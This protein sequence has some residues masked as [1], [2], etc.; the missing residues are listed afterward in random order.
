MSKQSPQFTDEMISAYLDGELSA[1]ERQCVEEVMARDPQY[2]QMLEELTMLRDK[3]KTL[4]KS[5]LDDQ[6]HERVLDRAQNQ[7]DGVVANSITVK[8]QASHPQPGTVRRFF[9][10]GMA[11][12]VAVAIMVL[13][14]DPDG[15]DVAFNTADSLRSQTNDR[16]SD[17]EIPQAMSAAPNGEMSNGAIDAP[18]SEAEMVA[19]AS[20]GGLNKQADR[21]S[22]STIEDQVP[23]GIADAEDAAEI[24]GSARRLEAASE[25]D[26]VSSFPFDAIVFVTKPNQPLTGSSRKRQRL[27]NQ[28]P[29]ELRSDEVA[30]FAAEGSP[31]QVADS[32]SQLELFVQPPESALRALPQ[33]NRKMNSAQSAG[34]GRGSIDGAKISRFDAE[35]PGYAQLSALLASKRNEEAS[36]EEASAE[37]KKELATESRLGTQSSLS[38][39]DL[40]DDQQHEGRGDLLDEGLGVVFFTIPDPS[41]RLYFEQSPGQQDRPASDAADDGQVSG[42]AEEQESM[43]EELRRLK[44]SLPDRDLRV[45]LVVP[46]HESSSQ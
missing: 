23:E 13:F 27:R 44:Q 26:A 33:A 42:T 14:R 38:T 5:Q 36:A 12:A 17:L 15:T 25:R 41:T 21:S 4:P 20:A 39:D 8:R 10:A 37:D 45:L 19:P 18:F 1:E 35:S 28:L 11:I 30:L 16:L 3:L 29:T 22:T 32:L 6:F 34:L 7:I 43:K 24:V 2:R 46:K 9:W 40:V 31:E